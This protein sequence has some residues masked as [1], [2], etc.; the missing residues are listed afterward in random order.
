MI[1][2]IQ[3]TTEYLQKRGFEAPEIGI[4]LGTGLGKLV[5]EIEILSDVSYNNIPRLPTATVEFH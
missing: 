3:E 1:R 4:I 2:E 5:D